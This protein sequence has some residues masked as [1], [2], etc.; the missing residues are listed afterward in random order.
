MRLP[1]PRHRFEA[2]QAKRR[3]PATDAERSLYVV[4]HGVDELNKVT[5]FRPWSPDHETD[6]VVAYPLRLYRTES[7]RSLLEAFLLSTKNDFE[8]AEAISMPSEEI[9]FYREVFFDTSV[10][11]TELE[12][13]VFM[14]GI[15]DDHPDKELY[16]V[17]FHQ[18]FGALRWQF[19]RKKGEVAA[20]DVVKT[21]MTDA[22]FRSLEHRGQLI[23]SKL[24]REAA[25]HAKISL[26]CA[27]ALLGKDDLNNEDA[28]NLK[29]KFEEARGNRTIEDIGGFDKVVH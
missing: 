28:E 11:R 5:P 23:N 17:A 26:E 6:E 27:R 4:L 19:C 8:I 22:F 12:L 16:R 18:G 10:F 25:K 7:I 15:P 2:L 24:A 13:I 21:V 3:A 14:R 9:S 29:I 20:P 1:N